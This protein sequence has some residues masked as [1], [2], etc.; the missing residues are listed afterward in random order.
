MDHAWFKDHSGRRAHAV[1]TKLANGFGLH[2][3]VGN[4]WQWTQDCYA[5][6]YVKAPTDGHAFETGN[7]C[8]RVDRGGSWLYRAWL[9]RPA[10]RERNPA[11][12]KDTIMGFRVAK[13]LP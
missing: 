6:S 5:D 12:Y 7:Q 8:M 13:T 10:T 4:V 11:D 3:M 2:D 1:G 9:L